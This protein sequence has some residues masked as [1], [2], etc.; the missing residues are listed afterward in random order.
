M[1]TNDNN[2]RGGR[3]RQGREQGRHAAGPRSGRPRRGPGP[4]DAPVRLAAP[5][6]RVAYRVL[7]A[8]TVDD[9]YAN[10]LLPVEIDRAKLSRAD[11]ALA[12]ELCYGTLR[13]RGYYDAV[14]EQ[15]AGRS[16]DRIDVEV[17]DVL[18]LGVHQILNTRVPDHAAVDE[19]VL[20]TR[21]RGKPAAS[22][23]VNGVLRTVSRT[24]PEDWTDRIVADATSPDEAAA[25][26]TAHPAWIVRAFRQSLRAEGREDEL[27][28]LLASDNEAPA[29][30]LVAL[31]GL[32]AAPEGATA[33]VYSPVG[34]RSAGGDPDQL[35]TSSDGRLRVQDEGSQLVALALAAAPV[36]P[37]I[38]AER[39]LDLCS[40]PGGK[41]ALLAARAL[42]AGAELDAVEL[43]PARAGLVRRAVSAVPLPVEVTVG[44]GTMIGQQRGER[45]ARVLVDAPCTGLGALRR[46]PEARWRKHPS[47]VAEL[48]LIQ[49]ALIRSAFDALVPGGVLA[50]VTCSPHIAETRGIVSTALMQWGGAAEL[51]DAPGVLAGLTRA[52]LPLGE[53][54]RE[55]EGATVQLW[56]HRHGT[57]AMFLAL[58]RKRA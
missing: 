20:L 53:P 11:A 39:W 18:R 1:S 43:V 16:L 30:N 46:R 14:I 52:E 5:A 26:A 37:S 40:G 38:T 12:T 35:V 19:S 34:F 22:G 58:V 3:S 23:F 44:D 10:L 41:T 2:A 25:R 57:D 45:Y 33:D 55:G 4:S 54:L 17:Q 13:L 9:A 15:A 28:A 31:P 29:V 8:V 47:D 49:L 51:L 6:R 36:D 21:E 48:G 27:A 7:H 42:A 24:A 56:P 50:Y 32:A